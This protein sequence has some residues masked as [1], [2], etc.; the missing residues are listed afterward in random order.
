MSFNNKLTQ[1]ARLETRFSL[2][3]FSFI[4]SIDKLGSLAKSPHLLGKEEEYYAT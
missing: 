1:P 3:E 4:Y 2:F